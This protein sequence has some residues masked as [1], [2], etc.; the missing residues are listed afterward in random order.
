ARSVPDWLGRNVLARGP[1]PQTAP[2][3]PVC[4]QPVF[5][6]VVLA[7]SHTPFDRVPPLVDDW[8]ALAGG[9]IY[10]RLPVREMPVPGGMIFEHDDGYL[11][12]LEY[13]LDAVGRFI[14]ERIGDDTLVI[15][16][17]GPQPPP[18]AARTAARAPGAVGVV[19][20]GR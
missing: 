17:G 7:S 18:T 14:A 13:V 16:L 5:A 1:A 6:Q 19:S 10:G 4:A 3:P 9:A 2:A 20:R 12:C 11:A 15:V 8:D